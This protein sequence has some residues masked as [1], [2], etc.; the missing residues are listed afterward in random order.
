MGFPSKY[1]RVDIEEF[2]E[3]LASLGLSSHVIQHV[4]T[5]PIDYANGV[6]AGTNDLIEVIGNR[7]PLT[8]EEWVTSNRHLFEG[9]GRRHRPSKSALTAAHAAVVAGPPTS[10]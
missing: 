8:V 4:T 1:D 2:K 5:V 7:T 6:F 10:R 9:N 3:G